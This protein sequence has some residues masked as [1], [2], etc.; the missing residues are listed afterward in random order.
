MFHV[1]YDF[2]YSRGLKLMHTYRRPVLAFAHADCRIVATMFQ[3]GKDCVF[4]D[5]HVRHLTGAACA[6]FFVV[7]NCRQ[8]IGHFKSHGSLFTVSLLV[9]CTPKP[10]PMGRSSLCKPPRALIVSPSAH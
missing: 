9:T 4:A 10:T 8:P 3:I 5:R 7:T 6:L 1:A 2:D